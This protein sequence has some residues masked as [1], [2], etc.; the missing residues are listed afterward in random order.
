MNKK[1][2]LITL[3]LIVL[4]CSLLSRK[5]APPPVI[6]PPKP[7]AVEIKKPVAMKEPAVPAK[8]EPVKDYRKELRPIKVEDKNR[9]FDCEPIFSSTKPVEMKFTYPF[10]DYFAEEKKNY[11]F[12]HFLAEYETSPFL[13]S[14]ANFEK[15]FQGRPIILGF[16]GDGAGFHRTDI[17]GGIQ[18]LAAKLSTS[19]FMLIDEYRYTEVTDKNLDSSKV[20]PLCHKRKYDEGFIGPEI[21][22]FEK[23]NV[24]KFLDNLIPKEELIVFSYSN[25][26]IPRNKLF[27][28]NYKPG[29]YPDYKNVPDPEAFLKEYIA[30]TSAPDKNAKRIK[31][32]VDVEGN[33]MSTKPAWDLLAFLKTHIEPDPLAFFYTAERI[34][35]EDGYPVHVLMIQALGLTGEEDENGVIT[36]TN[37]NKNIMIEIVTNPEEPYYSGGGLDLQQATKFEYFLKGKTE[38]LPQLNHGNIPTWVIE[39]LNTKY[40]DMFPALFKPA[41][42][43]KPLYQIPTKNNSKKRY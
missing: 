42:G 12:E 21:P 27:E 5:A 10:F 7:A 35:K 23:G 14:Y 24:W 39:R 17:T 36:Y 34:G 16:R 30:K 29:Y 18:R 43:F 19:L 20:M 26:T 15:R 11:L 22:A 41:R 40:K 1:N 37:L 33:Y 4:Q 13:I 6:V 38:R 8:K 25:G 31:G 3:S 28:R 32:I 9:F 2:K